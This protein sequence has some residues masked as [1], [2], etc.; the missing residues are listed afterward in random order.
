V[1]YDR[2]WPSTGRTPPAEEP[3]EPLASRILAAVDAAAGR[4]RV[5]TREEVAEILPD[6]SPDDVGKL[7]EDLAHLGRLERVDAAPG[8]DGVP[9]FGFRTVWRPRVGRAA[10][11]HDDG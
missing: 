8:R 5:A 6:L 9:T 1:S 11:P 10:A 4:D 3:S 2:V 7:L